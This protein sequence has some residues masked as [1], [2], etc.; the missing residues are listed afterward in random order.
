MR[1]TDGQDAE[2]QK[3]DT[4]TRILVASLLLFNEH[5]EPNTTTNAIADET[6][7]SPGNLHYHFR[8]KADLVEALLDEFQADVRRVLVPPSE[9]TRIEDFWVF[10]HLLLEVLAA[11]RFL[12][13]DME[14]LVGQYPR[15][16]D[17]LRG[18]AQGL[19]AIV[20]L[21]LEG[22][23]RAGNL[24]ISDREAGVIS[25]NLAVIALFSERFD[26]LM[27]NETNSGVS[28]MRVARS[29]LSVLF[30]YAETSI[31]AFVNELADQYRDK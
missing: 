23:G 8:K 16:R 24:R 19:T 10:L 17:S 25:R 21:Y 22:M 5:G 26:M 4:R 18:F 3:R 6:D 15:V 27:R 29:V 30:P 11:Y 7:I 14:T 28:V 1:K 9:E 12:L 13:R 20:Q 31:A 2:S